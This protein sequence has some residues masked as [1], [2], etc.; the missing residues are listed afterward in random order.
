MKT[1][2]LDSIPETTEQERGEHL[3]NLLY[4]KQAKDTNGK[5]FTPARY[6][7]A[8]GTKT[9][10]GLFRSLGAVIHGLD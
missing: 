10:L 1:N 9:A 2:P 6:D 4:L 7:T 5:R 3:A 8:W